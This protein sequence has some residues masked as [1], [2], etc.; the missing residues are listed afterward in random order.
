MPVYH[1]AP[2]LEPLVD[3]LRP[4]LESVCERH[5]IILVYV[6]GSYWLHRRPAPGFYFTASIVA[7]FSGAQLFA[8][9][10]IG[11]YLAWVHFRTMDQPT[12][13]VRRLAGPAPAGQPGAP[14]ADAGAPAPCPPDRG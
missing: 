7:L 1:G 3:R 14:A 11:E 2:S 6:V 9:G 4:V 10:I 8:L 5:E 13:A 12:Y